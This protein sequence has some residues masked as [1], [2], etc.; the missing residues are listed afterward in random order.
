MGPVLAA[1]LLPIFICPPHG[2]QLLKELL[3]RGFEKPQKPNPKLCHF[4]H[5]HGWG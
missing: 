2:G 1:Q 3:A 5:L 4:N